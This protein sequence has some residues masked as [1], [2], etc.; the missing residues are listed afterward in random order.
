MQKATS[1]P[2]YKREKADCDGVGF[3][4]GIEHAHRENTQ[5][6]EQWKCVT[7]AASDEEATGTESL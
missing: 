5:P 3:I 1:E 6:Q 7:L 2:G 4:R